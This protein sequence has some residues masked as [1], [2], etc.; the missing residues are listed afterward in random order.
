MGQ[1]RR[2]MGGADENAGKND[3]MTVISHD[4][5][6]STDTQATPPMMVVLTRAIMAELT[7]TAKEGTGG[8]HVG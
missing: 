5:Y 2:S 6:F 8:H 1:C 4:G 7:M 3:G